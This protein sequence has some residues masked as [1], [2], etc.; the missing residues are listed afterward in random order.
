[1]LRADVVLAVIAAFLLRYAKHAPR[2][3]AKV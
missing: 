2:R 3:W 1:M